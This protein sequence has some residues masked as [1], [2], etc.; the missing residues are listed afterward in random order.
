MAADFL[1]C[2]VKSRLSVVGSL[3]IFLS[4]GRIN[5]EIKEIAMAE[6]KPY[7]KNQK[8]HPEEQISN[9]AKSIEKYGFVQP[10]VLSKDNEIIIGHG[11]FLA[12]QKAGLEAVPCVYAENLTESQIKELRILDNKLNESAWDFDLLKEE[13]AEL[14]FSD[15]TIDFGITGNSI[16]LDDLNELFDDGEKKQKEPKMIQRPHCGEMFEA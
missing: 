9:I 10:L 8:K 3:L 14:D 6:I 4:K 2:W 12:A 15:F 13:I 16:T 7:E 11:R 1:S 5:M